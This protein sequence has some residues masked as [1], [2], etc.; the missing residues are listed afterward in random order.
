M[1]E[2]SESEQLAHLQAR[3]ALASP[4]AL[5][6][7]AQIFAFL[8]ESEDQML[9]LIQ[10]IDDPSKV[11]QVPTQGDVEFGFV[12][13]WIHN[14][15]PEVAA[16]IAK[17]ELLE[18][19]YEVLALAAPPTRITTEQ[20]N[21]LIGDLGDYGLPWDDG[22]L[23]GRKY[24]YQQLD[25]HWML[26]ALNYAVNVIDPDLVHALP[27]QPQ[28]TIALTRKDGTDADPVIGIV[29]DWGTGYYADEGGVDCPAQR[30]M[31]QIADPNVSPAIDYLFHLGDVYYA[32]TDLRP[33]PGEEQD[34]FYACGRTR[35]PAG[36]GR[37]IRTTRCTAP[38]PAI[39]TSPCSRAAR[40]PPRAG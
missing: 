27:D 2:L 24:R 37:S 30:V 5:A 29:G 35:V 18:F 4:D 8:V 23:Y 32:G 25:P 3:M 19:I 31:E 34:N 39:S 33:L 36:T 15:P 40:S 22:T 38:P 1:A 7:I 11:P 13:Y 20:Y 28:P 12:L 21:Q 26:A 14:P 9:V 16:F 6:S 17:S 10:Y